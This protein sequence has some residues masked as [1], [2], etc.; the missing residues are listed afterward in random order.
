MGK[1]I[2][3]LKLKYLKSLKIK[4]SQNIYSNFTFRMAFTPLSLYISIW[5]N[6]ILK[7]KLKYLKSLKIK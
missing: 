1:S 5:V 4:Y 6:A 2:L 7:L 3:K